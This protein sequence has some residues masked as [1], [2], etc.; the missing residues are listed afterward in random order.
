MA[1]V[2]KDEI[3]AFYFAFIIGFIHDPL[4]QF[5]FLSGISAVDD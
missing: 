1:S 3:Q 5:S 4:N 2:V